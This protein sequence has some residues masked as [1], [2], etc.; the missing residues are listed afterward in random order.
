MRF[1]IEEILESTEELMLAEIP[2]G[3]GVMIPITSS[4]AADERRTLGF[5][6]DVLL[7]VDVRAIPLQI[8]LM[9]GNSKTLGIF[10]SCGGTISKPKDSL[11][12][13]EEKYKI[14]IFPKPHGENCL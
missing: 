12:L 11:R 6:Y 3:Y 1:K 5:F 13:E 8:Y 4:E 9:E 14:H 10:P 2:L 7:D